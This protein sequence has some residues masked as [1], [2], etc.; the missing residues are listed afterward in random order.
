MSLIEIVAVLSG[1]LC[2][3]LTVRQS[4]WCWPTG[5][6]QVFLYIF[7]FYEAKL[8]SDVGLQVVYVALSLYGWYA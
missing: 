1:L 7:I 8:Y 6:L 3:A 4:L 5:L 2:V